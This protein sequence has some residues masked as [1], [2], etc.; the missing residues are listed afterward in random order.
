[1]LFC[2]IFFSFTIITENNLSYIAKPIYIDVNINMLFFI[3][4][5]KIKILFHSCTASTN[6]TFSVNRK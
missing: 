4:H 5:T 3:H 6:E 2:E 1:M